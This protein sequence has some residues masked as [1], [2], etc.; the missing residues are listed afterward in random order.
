MVRPIAA[1]P[2]SS[3]SDFNSPVIPR[4]AATRLAAADSIAVVNR[5]ASAPADSQVVRMPSLQARPLGGGTS[6]GTDSLLAL[7]PLWPA[8][9]RVLP[10]LLPPVDGQVEQPIV[11]IHRLH[12]ATD[13]PVSFEDPGSLS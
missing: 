4:I 10:H 9:R 3:N 6:I 1:R 2:G 13:R 12:P 5:T 11:V 7:K 8:L